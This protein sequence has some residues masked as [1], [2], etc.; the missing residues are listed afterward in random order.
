MR[1]LLVPGHY[2]SEVSMA[3]SPCTG[4]QDA[5]RERTYSNCRAAILDGK[6]VTMQVISLYPVRILIHMRFI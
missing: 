4:K 5:S 3:C 2:V 1:V 6:P